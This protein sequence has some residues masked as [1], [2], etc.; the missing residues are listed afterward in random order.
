MS[1]VSNIATN[2]RSNG[3][4]PA[5]HLVGIGGTGMKALAELLTGLGWKVTGSDQRESRTLE[6][7]RQSGLRVFTGH[8]DHCLPE[9]LDVLVYSPAIGEANVERAEA[10]K[11][12]IRQ[13]SLPMMLGELMRDKVGV[14]ITGTHGKSTTSAMVATI[15]R[16]AGRE[17]SAAFGAELRGSG[18]SGWAGK[19]DLLVVEGCEYQ[20]SFLSLDPTHALLLN[21]EMDHVDCYADLHAVKAAFREFVEKLPSHGLLVVQG[22]SA[23]AMEVAKSTKARVVT[24]SSEAAGDYWAADLRPTETGTRFRIFRQGD[25]LAE[26]TLRIPGPHNV[27]NALAATALCCELG[28]DPREVRDG[29]WDFPGIRRRFEPVGMWRGRLL[30]DDYA[31]HP[32]AIRTVI[33]AARIQHPGRRI[34]C[35]FQPHQLSR[36]IA[37]A[38]EFCDALALADGALI[39][40]I[41]AAREVAADEASAVKNFHAIEVASKLASSVAATGIAARYLP[42]LDLLADAVDHDTRPGDVLITMG[43]GDID[44]VHHEFSRRLCRNHA[45]G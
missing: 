16:R 38:D 39:V 30:I 7:M 25:Y 43:A 29:L 27:M 41:Y 18:R 19:G 10:T 4:R 40:P 33:E 22:G 31:H 44:R 9:S 32:T 23:E 24:F 12:G 13:L 20:R 14:A 3:R 42:S 17:P 36:T 8:D 34:W 11:R 2:V 37:L 6:R 45:A 21:V 1:P 15:L 5:A 26:M 28:V 35:A